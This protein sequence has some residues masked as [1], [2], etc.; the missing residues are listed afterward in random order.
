MYV[1]QIDI[2]DLKMRLMCPRVHKDACTPSSD[3]F[4][5]P[6]YKQ[7]AAMKTQLYP[8]PFKGHTVHGNRM[9]LLRQG[10]QIAILQRKLAGLV[11]KTN[12][13]RKT[14]LEVCKYVVNEIDRDELDQEIE[15]ALPFPDTPES[16][17]DISDDDEHPSH[18]VTTPILI[19]VDQAE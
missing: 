12:E 6:A 8:A 17:I 7:T 3:H 18:V 2:K 10:R 19:P 4:H 11:K 13:D 9:A 5:C 14:L 1:S 15:A 16:P